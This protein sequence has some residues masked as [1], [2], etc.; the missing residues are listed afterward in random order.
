MQFPYSALTTSN[1][2]IRGLYTQSFDQGENLPPP[3]SN[4]WIES[5]TGDQMATPD[6]DKYIFV[7]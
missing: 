1:P 4:F 7:E 2:I 3:V 6:G 5:S